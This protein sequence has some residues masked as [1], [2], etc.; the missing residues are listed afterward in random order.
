MFSASESGFPAGMGGSR[1]PGPS[2]PPSKWGYVKTFY[3]DPV[4]W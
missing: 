3:T 2:G 1:R 4:K